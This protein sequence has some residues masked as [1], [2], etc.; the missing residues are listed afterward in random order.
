MG[1]VKKY[2]TVPRCHRRRWHKSVTFCHPTV[3]CWYFQKSLALP[4][5]NRF[6]T[7]ALNVP[8][9]L[10][11]TA[12]LS[13]RE[14]FYAFEMPC[15]RRNFCQTLSSE[16]RYFFQWLEVKI[17]VYVKP[18]PSNPSDHPL[19]IKSCGNLPDSTVHFNCVKKG[20]VNV[21]KV[22]NNTK[23]NLF[24]LPKLQYGN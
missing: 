11:F 22:A 16:Q 1:T 3:H 18:R 19:T 24:I 14:Q 15:G 9:W 13:W 6:T 21:Q 23:H 8:L 4:K 10:V 2:L 12:M 20:C 7:H 5:Q 17:F